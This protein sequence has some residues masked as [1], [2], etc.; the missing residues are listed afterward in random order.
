MSITETRHQDVAPAE[1]VSY[2]KTIQTDP[3]P[4]MEREPGKVPFLNIL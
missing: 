2:S 3:M 1:V 4:E